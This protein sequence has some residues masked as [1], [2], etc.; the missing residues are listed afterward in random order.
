MMGNIIGA[1]VR[2]VVEA[3]L[4]WASR[5]IKRKCSEAA[6]ARI[7]RLCR[8]SR[9]AGEPH[10]RGVVEYE[11][12]HPDDLACIT[13]AQAEKLLALIRASRDGKKRNV[14]WL[15]DS[16]Y[17]SWT[18]R[19]GDAPVQM[20]CCYSR[21]SN[22]ETKDWITLWGSDPT[23]GGDALLRILGKARSI[24]QYDFS[25]PVDAEPFPFSA[26]GLQAFLD[27]IRSGRRPKHATTR[28]G[29]ATIPCDACFSRTKVAFTHLEGFR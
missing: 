2:R 3:W 15:S 29:D 25:L 28:R 5:G 1:W 17:V 7:V 20:L 6:D 18:G 26:Q 12:I 24:R 9:L 23:T 22:E 13:E 21:F 14:L 10:G 19:L 16:T 4:L 27:D 11:L 8:A